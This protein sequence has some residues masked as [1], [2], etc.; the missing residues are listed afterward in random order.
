MLDEYLEFR[1]AQCLFLVFIN[2]EVRKG[3]QRVLEQFTD[4]CETP[5]PVCGPLQEPHTCFSLS[6]AKFSAEFR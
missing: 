4:L 1:G 2:R 6:C 3:A 5:R